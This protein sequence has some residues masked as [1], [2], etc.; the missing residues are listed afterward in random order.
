MS[1]ERVEAAARV[2]VGGVRTPFVQG[3]HRL[4]RARHHRARRR[5]G[6]RAARAHRAAASR[7]R[8]DRLGRRDPAAAARPTSAARSRS[9]CELPIR[10]SRRM[11][12]TRACA[13]GLQAI[14]L[15]A[16]AI[17][18]GDADVDD[19]RR[20]ATRPATPRSSC[21]RR[22]CTRS[23]PLALRQGAR[24]PTTSARSAQLMPLS[25]ILPRAPEDR[26]AHDRRGDGRGR[27]ADGARATRSRAR[28]RTS[29]P[30]A[31]IS[32]P[33]PR[34]PAAAS[35]T[36]SCPVETRDGAWVHGDDLVRADTSVEKLAQAAP[37]VRQGR[38]DHRGQREPAH[39]R[40]GAR[41]C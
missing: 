4:Q 28:R 30:C 27:R 1:K 40:R 16:A 13:S 2:V 32:A 25:E 41:C 36:R 29:S 11:T 38:H 15:A 3:V 14:T 34:S 9:I 24:R 31:R 35:T 26:R 33:P 37:G 20:L 18:R 10:R 12:V 19:R 17:E 21:R 39:R 8:G 23:A 7:D 6:A 22:S 5:R